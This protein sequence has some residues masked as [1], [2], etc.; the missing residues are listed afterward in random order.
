MRRGP[1]IPADAVPL[2]L[3]AFG[4]GALGGTAIGGRLSDRRPMATT[5]PAAATTTLVLL[6][7][8]PLSTAPAAAVVLIFLMALAVAARRGTTRV[9]AHGAAE[10]RAPV[11]RDVDEATSTPRR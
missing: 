1:G 10:A 9:I 3:V 11:P 8:I 4:A 7:L 2:V 5:I 6:A